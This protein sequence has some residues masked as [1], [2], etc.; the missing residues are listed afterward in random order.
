MESSLDEAGF[1]MKLS[2]EIDFKSL[3]SSDFHSSTKNLFSG[4]RATFVF[5]DDVRL[6]SGIISV[7]LLTNLDGCAVVFTKFVRVFYSLY[8]TKT[9]CLLL[10]ISN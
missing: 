6:G 9:P 1:K 7:P 10:P 4:P 8:P 2:P 3:I 5:K